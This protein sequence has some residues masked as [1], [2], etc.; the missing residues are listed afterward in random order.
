[1]AS[2]NAVHDYSKDAFVIRHNERA[3]EFLKKAGFP[4]EFYRKPPK[5]K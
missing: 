3:R 1:M 5:D 2:S 4:K